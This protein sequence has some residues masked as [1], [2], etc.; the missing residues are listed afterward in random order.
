MPTEDSETYYQPT[1]TIPFLD[2]LVMEMDAWFSDTQ[3]KAA[4][5]LSLVYTSS[6]EWKAKAQE[7]AKFYHDDLP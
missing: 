5:G 4:L 1:L 2:Q 6:N 7:L 3:R